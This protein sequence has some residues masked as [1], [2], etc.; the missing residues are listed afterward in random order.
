MSQFSRYT[1]FVGRLAPTQAASRGQ[2]D[3][4][5]VDVVIK[6]WRPGLRKVQLTKTFRAG[7]VRLS[8]ASRLTGQVLEGHEVRVHLNQFESVAAARR[9]LLGLGVAEVEGR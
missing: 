4:R 2:S 3:S 7:G 6:G 5:G 1:G 9:A 8:E